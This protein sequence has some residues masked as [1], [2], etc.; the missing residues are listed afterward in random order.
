MESE[1]DNATQLFM[2]PN[3]SI[4]FTLLKD[5]FMFVILQGPFPPTS[6][7]LSHLEINSKVSNFVDIWIVILVDEKNEVKFSNQQGSKHVSLRQHKDI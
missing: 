7:D 2:V 5:N 4:L 6:F 3:K 1:Q